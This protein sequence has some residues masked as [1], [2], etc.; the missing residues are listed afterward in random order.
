MTT[1]PTTLAMIAASITATTALSA[2]SADFNNDGVVDGIDLLSITSNINQPC[3]GDCPSDLNNDGA[4]NSAD[5]IV[6]MQQ[7]GAVENY[8][9][10]QT[11]TDTTT[12]TNNSSDNRDMSWQGQGPVLLDALYYDILS[13][14]QARQELGE[15]LNQGAQ[16][17][18]WAAANSVAVQPM[19][20]NGGVD[21]YVD[22]EYCEDDKEKFRNWLDANVPADYDGPLC[23]DMEAQWWPLFDTSNQAVMDATID[24]YIEGLEYAQSLRP[25]AKI[26]YWGLPKKSNTKEN[27]TTAS[28]DRLLKASTAIFPDV[29][30]FN[31]IANGS[32]RLRRHVE[33]TM[34]IVE[35]QVPVYVQASPRYKNEQGQYTELHTVDEFMR[36]Q[37]DAALAA[38]WT[39]ANGTEH[40]IAGV[41][42]WDAYVY[43][44]W[45][46]ENWTNIDNSVRNAMW[47]E[48][49]SYHVELLKR[50]KASVDA[51]DAAAEER[52]TLA[53]QQND[54]AQEAAAQEAAQAA[55]ELRAQQQRKQARLLRRLN[56][57]K[58]KL[59]RSSKSY[60]KQ[61]R[62][63]RSKRNSWNKS[64]RSYRTA[65][66]SYNKSRS[67]YKRAIATAKRQYKS[68]KNRS[69]YKNA[70]VKAKR[71]FNQK[72]NQFKR[73]LQTFKNSR[74]GFQ[75]ASRT[76]RNQRKAYR[77]V[78]ANWISAKKQWRSATAS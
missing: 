75:K 56:N 77:N 31:P 50:M 51:A 6:L 16:A 74:T 61:A 33:K 57:T 29:Y 8:D 18:A 28:I 43:Y 45:Y 17:K 44:W 21:W 15:E 27:S 69:S 53:Q 72:R 22:G 76:F 48:L 47:E 12:S 19:A 5:I 2:Q 62:T 49:D 4:I 13:R 9:A 73:S 32:D 52:K 35:G 23:L 65:K 60:R 20:Y 63:F 10:Q 78:R 11:T 38:V 59:A 30:D 46:E 64:S 1:L 68:N 42:L 34:E 41:G 66:R 36:D 26:G 55:A 70:I 58:T 67:Q 40:R 37:V 71:Q 7:W 39:D 3:E 25:N 54:A 14:N 24:Y